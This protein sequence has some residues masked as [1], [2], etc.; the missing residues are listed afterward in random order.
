MVRSGSQTTHSLRVGLTGSLLAAGGP[1]RAV[2]LG[3]AAL[4][5]SVGAPLGLVLVWLVTGVDDVANLRRV[6]LWY[7]GVSTAAVFTAFGMVVGRL[8]DRVVAAR[9]MLRVDA[10]L[11]PLTGL[12]N[13]RAFNVRLH[14]EVTRAIRTR[15]PSALIMLDV[16]HFKRVNDTYGHPAGDAVLR[17]VALCMRAN[18]RSIDFPARYGGEEFVIIAPGLRFPDAFQ[19]AE[20]IRTTVG[21]AV[22]LWTHERIRVTIS[23]GVATTEQISPD[24]DPQLLVDKADEALLVAKRSGRNMVHPRTPPEPW[25]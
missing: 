3:L 15:Q 13:R 18:C 17:Q 5:L 23:A 14:D 21:R 8:L 6:T 4:F 11:D 1:S 10:G 25:R 24:A 2:R 9:E 19:V 16:D 12:A 20:R 22:T 7:V